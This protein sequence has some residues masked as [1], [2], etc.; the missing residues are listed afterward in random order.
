MLEEGYEPR[1]M[2]PSSSSSDEDEEGG[3][4]YLS[5]GD[6][7][8]SSSSSDDEYGDDEHGSINTGQHESADGCSSAQRNNSEHSV[9]VEECVVADANIDAVQEQPLPPDITPGIEQLTT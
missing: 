3:G 8:P 5:K 6:L 1:D 2:P 9:M 7:P 4:D